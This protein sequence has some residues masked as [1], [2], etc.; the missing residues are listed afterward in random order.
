MSKHISLSKLITIFVAVIMFCAIASLVANV[1]VNQRYATLLQN[2]QKIGEASRKFTLMDA[3]H[4]GAKGA[5]Y[6]IL[7]STAAHPAALDAARKEL[8]HQLKSLN[9]RLAEVRQLE[10]TPEIIAEL[11]TVQPVVD[12]YV[13]SIRNIEQ[14]A[15]TK[16]ISVAMGGLPAFET[17]FDHLAAKN[18]T[19]GNLI[20]EQ[21]D[22]LIQEGAKLSW[23]SQAISAGLGF[24]LVTLVGYAAFFLR[25]NLTGPLQRLTNALRS[26][27]S[28]EE[29]RAV[30]PHTRKDEIGLVFESLGMFQENAVKARVLEQIE[31]RRLEAESQ[32]Q[33]RI[34]ESVLTFRDAV[35]GVQAG[36]TAGISDLSV[37]TADLRNSASDASDAIASSS[38]LTAA[39]AASTQQIASATL[40]MQASITEVARQV[41]Q[42]VTQMDTT[43]RQAEI[44]HDSIQ[45]LA[46][47][48]VKIESIVSMIRNIAAQTNLLALNA[49]IEAARA[50]EA[51]RGFSV[52]AS[53]VKSLASQTAGATDEV[54]GQIAE[55][56]G[57]VGSSRGAIEE[58]IQRFGTIQ[59]SVGSIAS[60]VEQQR[61]ATAEIS[62]SSDT[63]AQSVSSTQSV[64]SDVVLLAE[65]ASASAVSVSL[66]SGKLDRESTALNQA[67]DGFVK[68]LA[69]A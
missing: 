17:A 8:D 58:M 29:L 50:G 52:V 55:I 41:G 12:A 37:A 3:H 27:G 2:S 20:S 43:A 7:F 21:N 54:A 10:T 4:D 22:S 66:V 5:L 16:G 14:R 28:D 38:R 31:A 18:E 19:A 47:S 34:E 67:V 68:S 1:L 60:V 42:S 33:R 40:E 26:L 63:A 57:L 25:K 13:S 56:L 23:L 69:A 6:R 45:R 39:N 65:R 61:A 46:E 44:A 64:L 62:L 51:G 9:A 49:T 36:L 11:A 15:K 35:V 59:H 53:E 48:T 24:F 32:R 30:A